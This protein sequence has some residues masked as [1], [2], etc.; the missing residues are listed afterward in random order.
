MI[1]V[2]SSGGNGAVLIV[3]KQQFAIRENHALNRH[4]A[5]HCATILSAQNQT[6]LN[7]PARGLDKQA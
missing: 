3:S 5:T 4:A 2:S 1:F 7:K 6:D